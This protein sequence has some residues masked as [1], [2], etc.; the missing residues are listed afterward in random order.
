MKLYENT[1]LVL[2][3]PHGSGK[4]TLGKMLS[5]R[6]GVPF[7]DEIGRYYREI[8][9]TKPDGTHAANSEA[10]FDR[11]V[12]EEEIARD[13][14]CKA[15]R[16][17]ETWHP[18]NLAYAA[19]RNR[20]VYLHYLS[21][22][23]RFLSAIEKKVLIQPLRID[24]DTLSRRLSEQGPTTELMQFFL[25]VS[26]HAEQLARRLPCTV[27]PPLS[28]DHDSPETILQTIVI[29]LCCTLPNP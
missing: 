5:E 13:V 8:E 23:Q 22:I 17:V 3:G 7:E 19:M 10:L 12:I 16:I 20:D 11:K 26:D 2:I 18:G 29:R 1:I 9:Q 25:K 27:L 6:L 15:P 24:T 28:T 4:T 21:V 14:L